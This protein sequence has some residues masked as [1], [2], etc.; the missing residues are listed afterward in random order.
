MVRVYDFRSKVVISVLV[1][2]GFKA[3]NVPPAGTKVDATDAYS[4]DNSQSGSLDVEEEEVGTRNNVLIAN[5]C[6]H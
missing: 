3:A 6:S 2:S 5:Y 1:T 4:L